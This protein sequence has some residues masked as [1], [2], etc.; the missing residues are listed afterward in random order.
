MFAQSPKAYAIGLSWLSP[1]SGL[2]WP[3]GSVAHAHTSTELQ[4][5]RRAGFGIIRSCFYFL[6]PSSCFLSHPK[7]ARKNSDLRQCCQL[8]GGRMFIVTVEL[9][10]AVFFFA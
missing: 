3:R 4:H 1:H 2:W 8:G 6:L 5:E 10:A 7:K 9:S